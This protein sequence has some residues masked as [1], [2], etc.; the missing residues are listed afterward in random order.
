MLVK[1]RDEITIYYYEHVGVRGVVYTSLLEKLL[2]V[3]RP[4]GLFLGNIRG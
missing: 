1:Y 3:G 4:S 2:S